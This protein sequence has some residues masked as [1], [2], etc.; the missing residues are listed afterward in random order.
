MSHM[1]RNSLAH[2]LGLLCQGTLSLCWMTEPSVIMGPHETHPQSFL[3]WKRKVL[4]VPGSEKA[5]RLIP[6]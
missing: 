1:L 6:M 3:L 2:V 4:C 5:E